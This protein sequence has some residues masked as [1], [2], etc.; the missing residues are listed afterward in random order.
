LQ[1]EDA[2]PHSSVSF[3]HLA[4]SGPRIDSGLLDGYAGV[5][6]A[7]GVGNATQQDLLMPQV[8]A[9]K[10]APGDKRTIDAVI[11]NIGA[12]DVGWGPALKYCA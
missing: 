1:I 2:D 3:V 8:D 7:Y 9:P 6:P 12:N 10:Q 5:N 4:R 11:I